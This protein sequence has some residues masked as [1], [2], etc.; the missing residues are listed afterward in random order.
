MMNVEKYDE[1]IADFDQALKLD[2]KNIWALADRGISYA[3]KGDTAAAT[4]DLDAAATLDPR[5]LIVFH[6]RGLVAQRNNDPK[7]AIAAYTKALEI[8]PSSGFA[9]G[10]RAEAYHEIGDDEHAL[11]DAAAA[12]K[13]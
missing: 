6:G 2:S 4:K 11:A 1:A 13:L 9:L 5:N 10:H 12:V 7:T 3:W 8:Y